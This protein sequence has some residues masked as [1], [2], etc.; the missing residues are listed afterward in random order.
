MSDTLCLISYPIFSGMNSAVS[1]IFYLISLR[2]EESFSGA[3]V[4]KYSATVAPTSD[5]VLKWPK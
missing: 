2:K 1:K 5:I 3:G 4:E